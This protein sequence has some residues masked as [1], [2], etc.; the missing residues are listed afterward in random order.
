MGLDH[1]YSSSRVAFPDGS[2]I[3]SLPN[4]WLNMD[5][6]ETWAR[7]APVVEAT[8]E[9]RVRDVQFAFDVMQHDRL[10]GKA[11]EV[12]RAVDFQRAAAVGHSF[13]GAVAAELCRIDTRFSAGANLDGWMF[14]GIREHGVDKPFLFVVED[15][16]FWLKNDGPFPDTSDGTGRLGTKDF[17]DSIYRSV[18]R[19]GGY[20][21]RP[22]GSSHEEFSDVS[23]YLRWPLSGDA[24]PPSQIMSV[25][26]EF[27]LAFL[28][29]YLKGRTS[30]LLRSSFTGN[31][32]QLQVFP[33]KPQ[34]GTTTSSGRE[35][36]G[37]SYNPEL[38]HPHPE[39]SQL[40]ETLLITPD[41]RRRN[42]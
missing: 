6:R 24:T 5:S 39:Y 22:F 1:P 37:R 25:T 3:D 35:T 8:L 17:H 29:Q 2:V 36:M 14:G 16:P 40:F 26:G 21:L 19:W 11:G 18:E 4:D 27:V 20:V 23:L 13:G 28:D 9:T 7:S 32:Y 10:Q 33:A 30:A 41:S 38:P 34:S 12:A 42:P 31:T 15:D